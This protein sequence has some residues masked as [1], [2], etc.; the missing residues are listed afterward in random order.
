MY[1]DFYFP[2][3][4]YVFVNTVFRNN[5]FYAKK[6]AAFFNTH[7]LCD[8]QTFSEL[9]YLT[10]EELIE[11][12]DLMITPPYKK[13]NLTCLNSCIMDPILFDSECS[14]GQ[15]T[16]GTSGKS[17]FVWMNKYNA[18]IYSYTFMTSFK[19]NGYDYGEKI[20]VFYPSNSYFTNEYAKSGGFLSLFNMYFLTF[21]KID[22][23]KTLEFVDSIN[24]HKPDLIVIFPFVLLQL[25][26]NIHKY[27]MNLMHYPKNINVSGEFLLHCSVSF[28]QKIFVG[29][30]IESTY[31]AVE[32]GEIA[33][34][35]DG[36]KNTFEVFNQFCFLENRGENIVVTSLINDTFPIIRY[37]MEDIGTIVNR[38]G[39]QYITNLIGKKSN[40]IIIHGK[41]FTSL[42]VDQLIDTVNIEGNIVSIVIDYDTTSIDIHYIIYKQY[43]AEEQL[44]IRNST[45]S[46]MQMYFYQVNYVVEFI[47]EYKH[48]YLKKF[49]IIKKKDNSDSEPVGGYFKE[50]F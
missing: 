1:N 16:G 35:V 3:T 39:K 34:Q 28:C 36:D 31:G 33:H 9:P 44:T 13:C 45:V 18:Y 17:T 10:K 12:N 6:Y 42:D 30:S 29:S 4:P 50:A 20:M 19:K 40:Q 38:D 46:F 22:R 48:N 2:S 26:M 24:T 37:I 23:Q 32:F 41:T 14:I 5:P 21:D 11:N 15:S 47:Q 7:T 25:C 43:S 8:K 27:S 49:K